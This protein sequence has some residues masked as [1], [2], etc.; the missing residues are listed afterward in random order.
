MHR[1]LRFLA[2]IA[3]VLLPV[4]TLAVS[5]GPAAQAVVT[6]GASPAV[7]TDQN[8]DEYAFWEN[9]NQGLE[10]ATYTPAA[11]WHA[12]HAVTVNGNG[13]GPLGSEPTVA[14]NYKTGDQYVFWMGTGSTPELWEAY[15]NANGWHGPSEVETSSG[16]EMGPLGTRPTADMSSDGHEYI[17][18][19]NLNSNL[20]FTWWDGHQFHAA[21]PVTLTDDSTK[22]GPLGSVPSA[23]VADGSSGDFSTVV[24][25]SADSSDD[26]GFTT[27]STESAN[28]PATNA[29]HTNGSTESSLGPLASQPAVAM[30]PCPG[31]GCGTTIAVWRSTT[32]NLEYAQYIGVGGRE[33]WTGPQA[34]GIGT[35]NSAPSITWG[36]AVTAFWKG[37]NG[38]LWSSQYSGGTWS[39]ADDAGFGLN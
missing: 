38:D 4:A 14:V 30:E 16:G 27:I 31:A 37:P 3:A 1:K 12:P 25:E 32:N 19:K 17:Y 22:I 9:S 39:P 26:L 33:L 20:E 15:N 36:P 5:S 6:A 23:A 2:I 29:M 13:M 18:W 28:F 35:L 10:T 11:G 24:W 8:G 7:G 34:S 21:A